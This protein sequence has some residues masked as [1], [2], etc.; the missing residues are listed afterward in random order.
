MAL[1]PYKENIRQMVETGH[2][3]KDVA[4]SLRNLGVSR[5]C[6]ES[7]IYLFCSKNDIHKYE[8]G[9]RTEEELSEMVEGAANSAGPTI[10]RKMLTGYLKASGVEVGE[11]VVRRYLPQAYPQFAQ[12]RR[13]GVERQTN[14]HP[15]NAE[16]PGHKLHMDQNEKLVEYGVTLVCAIDG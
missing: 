9:R 15:Y 7:N 4:S 13:M 6:S 14:S 16:Y 2:P 8:Y 5:G 11:C 3:I 1:E 10:G 12:E